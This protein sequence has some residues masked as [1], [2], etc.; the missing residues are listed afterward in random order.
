MDAHVKVIKK[1]LTLLGERGKT[2]DKQGS[3]VEENFTRAARMASLWL[4]KPV[5]ARDVCLILASVK[6]ARIAVKPDHADSFVD[7][8]NYVAFGAAFSEHSESA[9]DDKEFAAA[10]EAA[11]DD[12]AGEGPQS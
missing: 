4:N 11:V 7:L 10:L 2:Y 9:L 1:A 6:M 8:C 5:S 3:G 12:T